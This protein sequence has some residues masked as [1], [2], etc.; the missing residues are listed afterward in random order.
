MMAQ[1]KF[2]LTAERKKKLKK[3]GYTDDNIKEIAF[4]MQIS[5]TCYKLNGKYIRKAE[6]IRIL[7]EDAY[8]EGIGK[9]TFEKTAMERVGNSDMFVMFDSRKAFRYRNA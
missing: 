2:V 5:N 8:L 1:P 9:S 7:G 4:T 3:L 6:A